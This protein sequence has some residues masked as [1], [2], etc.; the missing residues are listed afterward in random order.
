MYT[1]NAR[2]VQYMKTN[3]SNTS[4]QQNKRQKPHDHFNRC[5]KSLTKFN[6]P[7][8]IQNTQ[9]A[10]ERELPPLL[11]GINKNPTAPLTAND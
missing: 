3:Q 11:N 4:Y 2:L 9:Q 6:T 10:E 5:N 8:H 1:N 7:L